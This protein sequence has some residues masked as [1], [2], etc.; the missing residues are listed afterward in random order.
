MTFMF[1]TKLFLF[2][3]SNF[4]I[5]KPNDYGGKPFLEK[6]R[7]S[8]KCFSAVWINMSPRL[9]NKML[10]YCIDYIFVFSSCEMFFESLQIAIH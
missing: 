1:I 2:V 9:T 3:C 10:E 6:R 7:H 5:M 8:I 4:S